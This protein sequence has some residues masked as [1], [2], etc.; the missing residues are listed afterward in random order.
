META[1]LDRQEVRHLRMYPCFPFMEYFAQNSGS[2]HS[3]PWC[4]LH[5]SGYN[6]VLVAVSQSSRRRCLLLLKHCCSICFLSHDI[7]LDLATTQIILPVFLYYAW[8][9]LVDRMDFS[10]VKAAQSSR[11][12]FKRAGSSQ[13][14]GSV[15]Q[16]ICDT[17]V[18]LCH[19]YNRAFTKMLWHASSLE[20]AEVRVSASH[21]PI[22]YQGKE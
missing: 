14:T 19:Q 6:S 13:I 15:G 2:A 18:R 21:K 22:L 7:N 17:T 9:L 3:S 8:Q 11:Q 20:Y 4:L 1:V 5:S 12:L 10:F 16:S